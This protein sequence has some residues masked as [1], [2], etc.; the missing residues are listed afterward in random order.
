VAAAPKSIVSM[1]S[2]TVRRELSE[3]VPSAPMPR[4]VREVIVTD[5]DGT[6]WGAEGRA[7]PRTRAA[8]TSLTASG[9]SI[10]AATARRARA[11]AQLLEANELSLPI[12]ALDGALGV[13]ADGR[14]SFFSPF[15][16]CDG[17][18]ALS[19]FRAHGLGPCVYVDEPGIDVILDA[20]PSTCPRHV[21]S[22]AGRYRT[23]DLEHTAATQPVIAFSVLGRPLTAIADAAGDLADLGATVDLVP[24]RRWP[25]WGL[26]V[27]A[28]GVSKWAG[29]LRLLGGAPRRVLAVG[30]GTNDLPLLERAD[31][32]VV[33]A[34]SRAA[35]ALPDARVIPAPEADG[36][37]ALVELVRDVGFCRAR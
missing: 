29:M 8:V 18:K 36:W 4:D 3:A 26:T 32:P 28:P 20:V 35:A 17:R 11:A 2:A 23:A 16:E 33:V 6:L 27:K 10:V 1:W 15:A 9:L 30:D 14:R 13:T 25:G 24:E 12:V 34:G 22:L 37:A 5:L 19:V 31:V 21:E 7:G